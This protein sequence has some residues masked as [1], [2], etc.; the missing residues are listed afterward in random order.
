MGSLLFFFWAQ[1]EWI[2][3]YSISNCSSRSTACKY[4]RQVSREGSSLSGGIPAASAITSCASSGLKFNSKQASRRPYQACCVIGSSSPSVSTT[5]GCTKAGLAAA[6]LAA[7]PWAG[8][9]QSFGTCRRDPSTRTTAIRRLSC[10]SQPSLPRS[11]GGTG[12][13]SRKRTCWSVTLALRFCRFEDVVLPISC[14][15]SGDA[16]IGQRREGSLPPLPPCSSCTTNL[17]QG[18]TGAAKGIPVV[19]VGGIP[20]PAAEVVTHT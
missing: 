5:D 9:S 13:R 15:C 1:A 14:C 11:D 17:A 19:D 16:R 7:D 3:G 20:C 6:A 12:S 2:P 8:T 10:S 4:C 18:G